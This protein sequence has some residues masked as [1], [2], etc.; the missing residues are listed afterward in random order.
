[1]ESVLVNTIVYR[2]KE[3]GGLIN[4]DGTNG[5]FAVTGVGAGHCD[6]EYALC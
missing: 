4:S 1:M 5:V 2:Q 3:K 6:K